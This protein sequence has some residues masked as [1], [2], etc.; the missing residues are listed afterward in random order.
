MEKPTH[1]E[2]IDRH[3]GVKVGQAKTRVAATNSVDKRD[4]AY[5]ACRFYAKAIYATDAK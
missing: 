5:G 4:N 1:Y 3:T 2:I